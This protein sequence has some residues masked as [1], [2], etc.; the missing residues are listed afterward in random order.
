MFQPL[1]SWMQNFTMKNMQDEHDSRKK[2]S[3]KDACLFN[4]ESERVIARL[5][6]AFWVFTIVHHHLILALILLLLILEWV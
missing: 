6:I 5:G 4:S 3:C 2:N 1:M